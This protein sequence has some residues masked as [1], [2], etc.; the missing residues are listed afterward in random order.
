MNKN[1]FRLS[2]LALAAMVAF[3]ACGGDDAGNDGGG[4]PGGGTPASSN[5]NANKPASGTPSEVTRLEFPKLA[6]GSQNL[7]IVHKASGYGVNYSVEWDCSK[8][9]QRW[10]CYQMY[11]GNTGSNWNRN[12]WASTSW[13]GDP[14]QEDTQIP[15]QYRTTLS[16]YR[17]SGYD[18]GHICPSAD[19]LFSQQVNEQTFY[20]SNMHP[21]LHNFND[22]IWSDMEG[23]IRTWNTN[24]F[25]DTLYVVK[26]GTIASGQ[27]L[28]PAKSG[29]L[30]PKYFFMAVLCVR[31]GSYKAIAFWAEHTNSVTKGGKLTDYLISVDELEQKTGIDFFCNL[32]DDTETRVEKV[33]P[34]SAAVKTAWMLTGK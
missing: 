10:T 26:G 20:L 8:K 19:R 18:R 24:S 13:G 9:A 21:Q 27:V 17:G 7:V 2:A 23:Q 11:A 1:I 34:Q 16:D 5:V 28:T 3:T 4:N 30:V 25:R 31:N 33:S 6:E 15:Q 29:L 22:G 32:P 12:N 14:F